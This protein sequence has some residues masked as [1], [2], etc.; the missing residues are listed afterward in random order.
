MIVAHKIRIYSN[1]EQKFLL[2]KSCGVAQFAYNLDLTTCEEE[3]RNGEK[4]S[5]FEMKKLFN[6]IKRTKISPVYEVTNCSAEDALL[7]W[8]AA[9]NIVRRT[10]SEFTCVEKS[11]LATE[12]SSFTE[13]DSVA[14][15]D[16]LN[17]ESYKFI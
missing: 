3:Y 9:V 11:V 2:K 10:T 4:I 13:V 1:K 16:S 17:R 7:N 12:L 5:S 14:K 15:L 8:N 6:S